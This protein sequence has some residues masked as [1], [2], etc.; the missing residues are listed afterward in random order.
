MLNKCFYKTKSTVIKI[1]SYEEKMY[2]DPFEKK[3]PDPGFLPRKKNPT[4][5]SSRKERK[6]QDRE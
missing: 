3:T 4:N 6:L 1:G 5:S 2:L